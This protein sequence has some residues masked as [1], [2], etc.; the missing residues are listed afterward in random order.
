M[1]KKLIARKDRRS[2][3]EREI[4]AITIEL[5]QCYSQDEKY[6]ELLT[7]LERLHELRDKNKKVGVS[8]D[9]IWNGIFMLVG[10]AAVLYHER[11][12]VI[13]SKAFNMVFRG[14]V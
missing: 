4:A 14:R 5:R 8:K 6:D 12:E 11:A 1:F 10:T 7:K 2:E 9:V 3:L 13:T